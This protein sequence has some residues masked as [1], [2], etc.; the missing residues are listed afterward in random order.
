MALVRDR[1]AY[2]ERLACGDPRRLQAIIRRILPQLRGDCDVDFLGPLPARAPLHRRD[3]RRQ[4]AGALASASRAIW[5]ACAESAISIPSARARSRSNSAVA[6][7]TSV[8]PASR[9]SA[10]I[11]VGS[12]SYSTTPIRPAEPFEKHSFAIS[13]PRRGVPTISPTQAV[14]AIHSWTRFES[15]AASAGRP[16]RGTNKSDSDQYGTKPVSHDTAAGRV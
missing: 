4:V 16:S 5:A 1:H 12:I 8:T 3:G 13:R 9:K 11:R 14:R 2:S 10:A 7:L 15:A 6:S